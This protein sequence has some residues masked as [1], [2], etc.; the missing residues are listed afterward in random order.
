VRVL[1][2]IPPL[3]TMKEPIEEV[4]SQ[5]FRKFPRPSG[6]TAVYGSQVR[7]TV[8]GEEL[9]HGRKKEVLGRCQMAISGMH[10]RRD[11]LAHE[12]RARTFQHLELMND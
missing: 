2:K 4:I 12:V 5:F 1:Y 3:F 7:D 8:I 9:F 6:T 10:G 11:H